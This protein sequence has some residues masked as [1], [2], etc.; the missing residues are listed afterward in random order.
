MSGIF[1]LDS[2]NL[3]ALGCVE[4]DEIRSTQIQRTVV[5]EFLVVHEG[6]NALDAG[7]A[8]LSRP[9]KKQRPRVSSEITPTSSIDAVVS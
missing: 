1:P 9:L 2:L 8:H 7:L 6:D 4:T 5:S 3:E